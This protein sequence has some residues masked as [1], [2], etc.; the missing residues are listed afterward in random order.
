M[1]QKQQ[2]EAICMS[3][4]NATPLF[5]LDL[6]LLLQPSKEKTRSLSFC[7]HVTLVPPALFSHL[8][9]VLHFK[10]YYLC[11]HSELF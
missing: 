3:V 5:L 9:F 2:N 11:S 10:I 6:F 4:A 1:T 7:A 8:V